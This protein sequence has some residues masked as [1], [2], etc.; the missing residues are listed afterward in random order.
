MGAGQQKEQASPGGVEKGWRLFPPHLPPSSYNP[1]RAS[2][3]F[4]NKH[5]NHPSTNWLLTEPCPVQPLP[6]NPMAATRHP[7]RSSWSSV[8]S[9]NWMAS[10][11][12]GQD[13][14]LT[15]LASSLHNH[16]E[17]NVSACFL[18]LD[19]SPCHLVFLTSLG[20]PLLSLG[21]WAGF[22]QIGHPSPRLGNHE[23][24][25]TWLASVPSPPRLT[26]G[27][28]GRLVLLSQSSP[29]MSTQAAR[30][31]VPGL[32]VKRG[33]L[34]TTSALDGNLREPFNLLPPPSSAGNYHG[35]RLR[36]Q[37]KP[38]GVS[39]VPTHTPWQRRLPAT[40]ACGE[41]TMCYQVFP[42][43]KRS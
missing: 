12:H 36:C 27:V 14:P 24:D 15:C 41:H 4:R 26:L 31:R 30:G 5:H 28:P 1:P 34:W 6:L 9:S 13:F 39:S 18:G 16:A 29:G 25:V 23:R 8:R 17:A 3:C 22:P 37:Q 7:S 2:L 19:R 21:P 32:V 42:F 43:F 40:V 10:S 33:T 38:G 11:C 20:T 35:H